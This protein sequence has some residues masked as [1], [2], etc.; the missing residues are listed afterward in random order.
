MSENIF[1]ELDD[2][3]LIEISADGTS[4]PKYRFTSPESADAEA[5][6]DTSEWFELKPHLVNPEN[7]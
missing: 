6:A 5:F 7:L 4:N 1:W 3:R 2:G